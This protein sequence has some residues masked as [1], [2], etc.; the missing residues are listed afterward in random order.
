M[1]P[2]IILPAIQERT[3]EY[4]AIEASIKNLF[5]KEIYLPILRELGGFVPSS[6]VLSNSKPLPGL[7]QA[8][9]TGRVSF[10]RGTFSGKFN[11]EISKQLRSLGAVFKRSDGTYRIRLDDLPS[12][13]REAVSASAFRF[14]ERIDKIDEKLYGIFQEEVLNKSLSSKL[15]TDYL[16]DRTLW[17]VDKEFQRNVKNITIAPQLTP[18]ARA[19]IAAQWGENMQLWVSDFTKEEILQLR[20]DMQKTVFAGNR[21]GAAVKTI[22]ASYEVTANKAKFLAKQETKL[23]MAAFKQERYQSAGIQHY[24]WVCVAG[25]KLHP[26]RP[27][28]KKNDGK[29]FRFDAPPTVDEAGHRK[30]P[31]QDYN[32]RCNARPMINYTGKVSS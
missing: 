26:V 22:Q 32:C 2:T 3:N 15:Q 9:V 5:K 1:G 28:H 4:E 20:V 27:F 12:E 21:Y 29:V 10:H 19:K 31:Q 14:Q 17:K 30:N 24:K 23:L 16:F 11:S 18:H 25:S 8:L 7:L 6:R 13:I